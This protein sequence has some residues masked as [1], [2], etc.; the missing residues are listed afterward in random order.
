MKKSYKYF[1]LVALAA[2]ALSCGKEVNKNIE[3]PEWASR[4]I[5][6]DVLLCSG[7]GDKEV[8]AGEMV[9]FSAKVHDDYNQL[10]NCSLTVSYGGAVVASLNKELGGSQTDVR[11]EFDMPFAAN[12]PTE[13]TPE[14][15]FSVGNVANGSTVRRLPN[16]VNVIV[17]RPELGSTLYLVDDNGNTY[18]LNN[19][20]SGYVY[21]LDD[22]VDFSKFGSSFYISTSKTLSSDSIIW[23]ISDGNIGVVVKEAH[24]AIPTSDTGGYGLKKLGFN[25]YSFEIDELVNYS[26]TIKKDEM[27]AVEQGGVNYLVAANIPLIR[28]CE[29]VFEGFDQIGN[30]LQ[31]D[32]F[33]LLDENSAK[34]TGH[35]RNWTF[36]YDKEDNWMILNYVHNN[37]PEQVW[38]TGKSA[39]FPLGN[40]SSEHQFN[41]LSGD[42]KDRYG[43]LAAVMDGKGIYHCLVYFMDDFAIQLYSYVK[44]STVISMDSKSENICTISDDGIYI[45]QGSEFKPGVY[46][47]NIELT[48]KPNNQ[49][50][51]AVA[52]VEMIPYTE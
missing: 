30:S 15:T 12:L 47:L 35:P 22:N 38:V 17:S 21:S 1:A 9:V 10:S 36:Y 18:E 19:G 40:A 7:N 24:N 51:G 50:D 39:C 42:G 31:K 4:P 43:T 13:V 49:G 41:Y 45:R 34:F 46:M 32:R 29:V 11:F 28:N 3:W 8:V 20:G 52:N 16:D 14:V 23:G 27:E 2:G 37:D 6:E 33:V 25:A 5:V 26:V 48:T 44:W